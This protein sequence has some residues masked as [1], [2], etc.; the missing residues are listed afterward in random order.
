[1]SNASGESAAQTLRPKLLFLA[2]LLSSFLLFPPNK[3]IVDTFASDHGL[4]AWVFWGL[5]LACA[6][7]AL[8]F[9][10][11]S[12][13]HPHWKAPSHRGLAIAGALY[14]ETYLATLAALA[15]PIVSNPAVLFA[16][17]LVQ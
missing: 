5:L 13:R 15:F 17:G 1:M 6:L 14:I 11:A 3:G 9:I 2:P 10:A 8:A 7:T 4:I 16:F 12:M